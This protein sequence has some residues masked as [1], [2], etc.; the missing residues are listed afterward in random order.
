M[1]KTLSVA[2]ATTLV[3][4]ALS[5][6]FYQQYALKKGLDVL[7]ASTTFD[8]SETDLLLSEIEDLRSQLDD[9]QLESRRSGFAELLALDRSDLR[10]A[11][12]ECRRTLPGRTCAFPLVLRR[13]AEPLAQRQVLDLADAGEVV[14][15]VHRALVTRAAS[16]RHLRP[17]L[18]R[19]S[20]A[21]D[22]RIN[23]CRRPDAPAS[24][25]LAGAAIEVAA[26]SIV[27]PGGYLRT[28][29]RNTGLLCT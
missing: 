11:R 28:V 18:C 4:A 9:I 14:F 13:K 29:V 20:R 27:W 1:I 25:L 12:E 26:V 15:E 24:R 19:P 5:V 17:R 10:S 22:S 3:A 7:I 21:A 2:I 8:S 6:I 23:L 16:S